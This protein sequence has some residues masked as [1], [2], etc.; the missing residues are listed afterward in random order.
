MLA[1]LFLKTNRRGDQRRILDGAAFYPMQNDIVSTIASKNVKCL[2]L[3]MSFTCNWN[4][5]KLYVTVRFLSDV[6]IDPL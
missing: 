3:Q 6:S 4:I 1:I 5:G 2:H